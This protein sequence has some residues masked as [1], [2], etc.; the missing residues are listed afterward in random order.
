MRRTLLFAAVFLAIAETCIAA[1]PGYRLIEAAA[2]SVNGEVIFLSDVER[3]AC[4]SRCGAVPGQPAVELAFA[5]A[6]QRLVSDTLVLQEQKKLGLGG[7]DNAAI[8]AAASEIEARMKR[9]AS[10]CAASVSEK[11]ARELASRRLMVR[12][13]L[14]RSVAVFIDVNEEEVQ[15]EIERRSRAGAQPGDLAPEKVRKS[16]YEAKAADEIRN[17]FGRAASKSR[18]VLSPQVER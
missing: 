14:E 7:V 4:F 16:L 8:A 9:C 12:D 13:F 5:D 17:W 15:R 10:P 3:E 2:A 1:P 18:I 11:D 6:R